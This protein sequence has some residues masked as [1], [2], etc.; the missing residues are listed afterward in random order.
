MKAVL[1]PSIRVEPEFLSQ[2][3]AV[4][5]VGESLPQFIEIA[6]RQAVQQRMESSEFLTRGLASLAKAHK[7]GLFIDS[8]SV[9]AQLQGR[10][11]A[12]RQPPG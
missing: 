6:V 10:T 7:E 5:H 12:A 1:L 3:Q 2:M 11:D 9:L 4:L 8:Q